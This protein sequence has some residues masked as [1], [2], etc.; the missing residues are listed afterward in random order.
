MKKVV[1]H[2]G[3]HKTGTTAIQNWLFDNRGVLAEGGV[4]SFNLRDG[5]SSLIKNACHSYALGHSGS[6][7]K[8]DRALSGISFNI[9][10]L[11]QDTICISDEG[12]LGLIPGWRNSEKVIKGVYP[13]AGE[14]VKRIE[15]GLSQHDVKFCLYVRN[16]EDWLVSCWKQ[17]VKSSKY[18]SE[19]SSYKEEVHSDFKWRDKVREI[20]CSLVS[21]SL[22]V[23]E[24]EKDLFNSVRNIGIVKMLELNDVTLNRCSGELKK[25]NVSPADSVINYRV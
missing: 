1:I 2:L 3:A 23:F 13:S 8:L 18:T 5:T 20:E 7:K 10:N 12:L 9:D 14:I 19:F 16:E 11:K 6:A 15:M 21:S 24:Y 25:V 22:S 17:L 4:Y